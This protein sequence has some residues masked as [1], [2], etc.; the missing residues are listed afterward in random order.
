MT[1]A[2]GGRR[3]NYPA[4]FDLT[5]MGAGQGDTSF[6]AANSGPNAIRIPSD[7]SIKNLTENMDHWQFI[8]RDNNSNKVI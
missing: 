2:Y 5:F 1:A 4:D 7:I 6:P 3:V 8:F